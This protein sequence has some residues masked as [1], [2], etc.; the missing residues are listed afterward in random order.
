LC[1]SCASPE[2]LD[3]DE[4]SGLTLKGYI[5]ESLEALSAECIAHDLGRQVGAVA[6]LG[7]MRKQDSREA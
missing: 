3:I 1:G 7:Q 5:Q 6:L 4:F 2:F